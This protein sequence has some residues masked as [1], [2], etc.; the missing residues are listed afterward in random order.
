MSA[1]SRRYAK[2]LFALAKDSNTLQPTADQLLR[3]AAVAADPTMGPVLCSPMLSIARRHELAA[4]LARELTL[5]DLLAH[6]LGLLADHQRLEEL[7]AIADRYQQL[8]DV[9]L[10]R[11]RLT[12]RSAAALDATQEA[13]V[14]ST[15]ATLTGKQIVSRVV[16]DGDLLGGVVVEVEGK[17]YDGSVRTQLDR[18]ASELSGAASL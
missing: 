1:V 7:P 3:L 18:L 8:L 2:A 9:Q 15:F 16:V 14:V 5:S 4:M 10:G 13:D 17:V 6:F 11:V 12:I